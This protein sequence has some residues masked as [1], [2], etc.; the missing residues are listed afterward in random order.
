[1]KE[2]LKI[3]RLARR[4][5]VFIIL[6]TLWFLNYNRD[7]FRRTEYDAGVHASSIPGYDKEMLSSGV[8]KFQSDDN[9]VYIKP[10]IPFYGADHT[11]TICWKGSGYS[12]H[13]EETLLVASC[14]VVLAEL[15]SEEGII[16]TAWWYD[17][18]THKT[19]AQFDWR[20]R[21]MLG[22]EPFR[23][24]NVSSTSRE[25]LIPEVRRIMGMNL[26]ESKLKGG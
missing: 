7:E 10:A 14:I 12:F 26:F 20:W 11:P 5:L 17:N 1:M 9:L 16:H 8:A 19:G 24:V 21:A 18:G 22:E 3:P 25:S 15:Q 6:P 23:I 2:K 13:K 4:I